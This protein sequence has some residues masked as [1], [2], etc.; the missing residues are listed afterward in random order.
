MLRFA[1]WLTSLTA[2]Q[3]IFMAI[4]KALERDFSNRMTDQDFHYYKVGDDLPSCRAILEG[5]IYNGNLNNSIDK[6]AGIM[7]CF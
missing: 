3:K 6:L 1:F 7:E 4:E 5:I 2:N